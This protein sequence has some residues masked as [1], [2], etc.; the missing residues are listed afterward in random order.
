M[1]M[2]KYVLREYRYITEVYEKIIEAPAEQFA[3]HLYKKGDVK[4]ELVSSI[5]DDIEFQGIRKIT[6]TTTEE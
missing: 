6:E 3:E 2:H 5:T 1:P 4:L